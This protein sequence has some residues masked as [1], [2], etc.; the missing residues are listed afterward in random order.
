MRGQF[1]IMRVNLCRLCAMGH[2]GILPVGE[3]KT[4]RPPR[5]VFLLNQPVFLGTVIAYE[6]GTV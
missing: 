4:G 2:F 3:R 6:T 1:F 5:P